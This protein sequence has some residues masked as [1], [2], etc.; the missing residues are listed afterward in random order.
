MSPAYVARYVRENNLRRPAYDVFE[1]TRRRVQ[2]LLVDD[3]I[4]LNGG[5]VYRAD[6]TAIRDVV[7]ARS[8]DL[9]VTSPPYLGLLRYG[10]FNW[11]RL[12]FLQE[13]S[14][15]VDRRLDSTNSLDR[16]SSFILSALCEF[17]AV[18]RPGSHCVIV[19]GELRGRRV[20]SLARHIADIVVPLTSWVV[21][22]I[23]NDIDVSDAK[24]TRIWGDG[25]RGDASHR[26]EVLVLRMAA[27]Q[28]RS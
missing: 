12:W 5:E 23:Q 1:S 22:S 2:H 6:A 19:V 28:S 14:S 25:R 15:I 8:V 9:I 18:V 13:D 7:P 4:S 10:A 24:T 11:L 27:R 17:E 3:E 20:A 26:D 21:V 16:Y